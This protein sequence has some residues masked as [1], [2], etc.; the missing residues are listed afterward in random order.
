MANNKTNNKEKNVCYCCGCC[1][2]NV[3][4]EKTIR[5]PLRSQESFSVVRISCTNKKIELHKN[6]N[7]KQA[8][9]T[10]LVAT[11]MD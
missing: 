5:V 6:E 7:L 10:H 11:R 2:T 8:P 9:K 4:S 1:S 3:T